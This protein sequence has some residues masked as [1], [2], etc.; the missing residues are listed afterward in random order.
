[1]HDSPYILRQV[2]QRQDDAKPFVHPLNPDA[3]RAGLALG[4][5]TGLTQ[6]GVHLTVLRPGELSTEP[7]SHEF[8]DE[9]LFILSGHG[10]LTLGTDLHPVRA[11]DFIGCPAHG[12]AHALHNDGTENLVYLVGGGRPPFDVVNY[13]RLEKRLY[14]VQRPDGRHGEFVDL[15]HLAPR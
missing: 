5:A 9:F 12:P 4:D 2:P 11:G 10:Q 8:V 7:H 13:P 1:M 14:V 3:T 15:K 6:L